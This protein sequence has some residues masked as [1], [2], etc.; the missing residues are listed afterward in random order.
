[1]SLLVALATL[2]TNNFSIFVCTHG[3]M[4]VQRAFGAGITTDFSCELWQ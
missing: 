4:H 1:M 3:A 2:P